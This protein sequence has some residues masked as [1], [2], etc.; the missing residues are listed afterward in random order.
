MELRA[1]RPR[2]ERLSPL[3]RLGFCDLPPMSPGIA[4]CPSCR[5]RV[6]EEQHFCPNCG[7]GLDSGQKPDDLAIPAEESW[8]PVYVQDQ[9]E[10]VT[11][12][13]RAQSRTN[14]GMLLMMF[15]FGLLW[16]PVLAYGGAFLA[17]VGV[18]F[19]WLGRRAFDPAYRRGVALGS[20]LVGGAL[21]LEV[22]VGPGLGPGRS[23]SAQ[24]L[25]SP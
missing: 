25:V 10:S 15:G 3:V 6:T 22:V 17:F 9:N 18:A 19:L 13:P 2:A 4:L 16:V 14:I 8:D 12:V 21:V 23:A 5:H 24:P 7:H 20:V 1:V 11:S